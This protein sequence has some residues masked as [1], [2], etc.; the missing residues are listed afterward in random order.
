MSDTAANADQIAY[1]NEAAGRTWAECQDLLDV[2]LEPLGR[3]VLDALALSPGEWV[4][5]VGCGSGQT[6]LALAGRIGA[7]GHVVGVDISQPMLEVARRRAEVAPQVAFHEA[8]AQT[9][10]FEPATFDAIHSRFGVMF[11]DDPAAAFFNLRRALRPGGRLA[12]VCWRTP[13]ENPI[14]TLPMQAAAAHLP[15]PEPMVPGAPGPFAFADAE[16]VRTILAAVGFGDI[17][18]AP[19]DMPAGGNSVEG[20]VDLAL[21]IGPLGRMLRE[22]PAAAPAV[23]GAIRDLM[24]ESAGPD[25]RVFLDSATWIVTARNP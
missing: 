9:F 12:F 14:M 3:A 5:D 11:F 25:G 24:A 8:D 2:Q 7:A 17:A 10:A 15:P 6:T 1:W 19:Q 22:H 18:I 21:K 13:A 23:V 4:L 16:R 20:A